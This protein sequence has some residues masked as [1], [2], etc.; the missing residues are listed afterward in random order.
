MISFRKLS[1][2]AFTMN[3]NIRF[4]NE[5]EIGKSST[6]AFRID[7]IFLLGEESNEGISVLH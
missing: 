4:F 7:V 3:Y 2:R 1:I 6:E 5:K